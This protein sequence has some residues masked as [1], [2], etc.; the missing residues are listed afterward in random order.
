VRAYY[1]IGELARI[2]KVSS[3]GLLRLLRRNDVAFL[4]SGRALFVPLSEIQRKIPHL[5][6]GLRSAEELRCAAALA[7]RASGDPPG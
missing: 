6:E 2:A 7:A 3:Y 1:A 4:R 5:W